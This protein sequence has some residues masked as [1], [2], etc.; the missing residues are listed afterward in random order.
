[1]TPGY[2]SMVYLGI[3][4]GLTGGLGLYIPAKPEQSKVLPM[5]L[6][7]RSTVLDPDQL[8][9]HTQ[10]VAHWVESYD[11]LGLIVAVEHVASRPRQAGAFNF[12]LSTGI[13]HGILAAQGLPF[14]TVSPSKWKP[15]MG[16]QRGPEET[17]DQN[18]DRARRLAIRLFPH[19][20]EDLKL[21]KD[22]GKAEALLLA[23]YF[24]HSLKG[25]ETK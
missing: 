21:K 6:I 7:K 9:K 20:E 16:L 4:P 18:K 25:K 13:I 8:A 19:L 24:H 17:Y 11:C 2:D 14:A 3:D 22:D 12:G 5:P 23:V 10:L 1:M 15:A